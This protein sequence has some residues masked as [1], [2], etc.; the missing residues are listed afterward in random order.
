MPDCLCDLLCT[1][2][3]S[4]ISKAGSHL[5]RFSQPVLIKIHHTDLSSTGSGG[6]S[7]RQSHRTR[8]YD[9][10]TLSRL[11][12]GRRNGSAESAVKHLTDR[13]CFV[14][15]IIRHSCKTIPVS[16]HRNILL[17]CTIRR[18]HSNSFPN[19]HIRDIA[20]QLHHLSAHLMP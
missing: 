3:A 4:V 16:V 11:N 20:A 10:D 15:K 17:K 14:G 8:P 1:H 18:I 12:L 5:Q 2:P 7:G 19:L 9:K 6:G 13:S